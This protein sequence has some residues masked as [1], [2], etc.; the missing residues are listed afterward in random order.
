MVFFC[1]SKIIENI[2]EE[3]NSDVDDS[4]D[5]DEEAINVTNRNVVDMDITHTVQNFIET[6]IPSSELLIEKHHPKCLLLPPG[7]EEELLSDKNLAIQLES[8]K[9]KRVIADLEQI[10]SLFK[11]C[12][13]ESCN[14]KVKNT[15]IKYIGCGTNIHWECFADHKGVWCS[16]G[17]TR[18]MCTNNLMMAMAVLYSGNNISKINDFCHILNLNGISDR[19]FE[20]IQRKYLFPAIEDFFTRTQ[21]MMF[22]YTYT[23]HISYFL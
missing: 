2:P 19:T 7:Y 4:I 1:S 6:N 9:E 21:N 8:V 17:T 22:R 10:L 13:H 3:E 5:G 23:S 16:S 14:S 20:L 18:G 12:L 15:K 11:T